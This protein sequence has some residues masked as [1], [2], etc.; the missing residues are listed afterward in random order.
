[1]TSTSSEHLPLPGPDPVLTMLGQQWARGELAWNE[2]T[3]VAARRYD[4][5][6]LNAAH[7]AIEAAG[8]AAFGAPGGFLEAA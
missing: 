1:M 8:Y 7:A 4:R 6:H 3:S 5:C 2:A